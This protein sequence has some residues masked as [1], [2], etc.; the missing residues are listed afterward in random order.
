MD[1]NK[2]FL[3]KLSDKEFQ[4]VHETL[5]KIQSRNISKLDIRKLSGYKD[6]YRVRAGNIRII[7]LDNPKEIQILEIARRSEKTY[8]GF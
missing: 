2:K 5:G 3:K 4:L 7:F 6:V 8:K 1:R